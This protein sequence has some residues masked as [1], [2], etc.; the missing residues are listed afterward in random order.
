M[1]TKTAK[2]A[3]PSAAKA[4]KPAH[5]ESSM[6]VGAKAEKSATSVEAKAEKPAMSVGVE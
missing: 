4:E 5:V 2:V 1:K 3:E 6:S